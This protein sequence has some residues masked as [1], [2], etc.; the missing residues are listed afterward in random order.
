MSP[1][2][3]ICKCVQVAVGDFNQPESLPEAFKSVERALL[4]GGQ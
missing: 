2:L 3:G 4:L 1:F